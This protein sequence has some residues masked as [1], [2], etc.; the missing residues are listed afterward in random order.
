MPKRE[1]YPEQ[2]CTSRM[3]PRGGSALGAAASAQLTKP[4]AFDAAA[5]RRAAKKFSQKENSEHGGSEEQSAQQEKIAKQKMAQRAAAE[6]VKIPAKPSLVAQYKY[7]CKNKTDYFW[8]LS[9]GSINHDRML[10][11]ITR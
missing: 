8:P 2:H 11:F 9:G 4:R 6:Q 10:R 3:Q 1:P 5:A 7:E